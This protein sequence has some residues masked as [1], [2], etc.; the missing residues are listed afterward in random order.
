MFIRVDYKGLGRR[1]QSERTALGLTQA[2][3]AEQMGISTQYLGLIENGKR[4]P[5]VDTLVALCYALNAPVEYLL[6]DSLPENLFH[7]RAPLPVPGK[8]K[9]LTLR[10]VMGALHN[11]LSDLLSPGVPYEDDAPV[12][13]GKLPPIGFMALDE[14]IDSDP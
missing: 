4:I 7:D 2:Q 6:E 10:Q 11:T 14:K 1:V 12:D 3:V 13:L 8:S 5:S 9:R